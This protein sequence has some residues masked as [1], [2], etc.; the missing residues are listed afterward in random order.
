VDI[1]NFKEDGEYRRRLAEGFLKEAR[2]N[3]QHELWR[4]CVDN[5]QLSIENSCKMVIALLEPVEKTHNPS[6][7]IKRLSEGGRLGKRYKT[8]VDEIIDIVDRFGI[9]EHF[10]TDYGDE[11]TR[12]DPWSLFDREDASEALDMAEKCF[13]LAGEI[14]KSTLTKLE[15]EVRKLSPEPKINSPEPS[16]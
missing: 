9:E 8:E 13:A 1:V 5:S 14:F 7:Q 4:S 6:R 12:T 16:D 3:F 2:H 10:M 15:N 11:N